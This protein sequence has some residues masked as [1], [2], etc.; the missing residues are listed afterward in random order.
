MSTL[1]RSVVLVAGLALLTG[2]ATHPAGASPT[3]HGFD[4]LVFSKT[5]GFRHDSIDEGIAAIEAIGASHDFTVTA[6]EDASVFSDA[7]LAAFDVVIFLSTTGDVL[8]ADQQAALER[9]VQGGGGWVGIHAAADTEYG[10]PWYGELVGAWF[11]SHPATQ[12][13]TVRVLDQDHP[14][15]SALQQVWSRTDEWY[16][17]Q[18]NPRGQVHVLATLD[19]ASYNGGAMGSDHPIAWCRPYDGGRS[20]YTGMGHTPESFSEA[21]FREH[22]LGGIE[23]AA[24]VV[25]GDCTATIGSNYD[26]EV[27]EPNV[28]SPMDLD[29]APDGSVFFVELGGRVRLYDPDARFTTTV[30]ELD[31]FQNFEDGLIGIVL[32]PAFASNGWVYLFYSPAGG[33]PRQHVSRF[34]WDGTSLDLA[35]ELSL[36]HI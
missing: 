17:Y 27:L 1:G 36:I 4:A 3:S 6:T 11:A 8:D 20:W 25:E 29:V 19:D 22:L 7:G 24:G 10:W 21:D 32:D 26:L 9:F 13:A 14:S 5:E 15:T 35:T 34:T 12:S 23:W 2:L 30:A 28:E 33:A 31:V 16:D 18:R